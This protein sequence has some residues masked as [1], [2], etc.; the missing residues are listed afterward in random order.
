[1]PDLERYIQAKSMVLFVSALKTSQNRGH[2]REE[3]TRTFIIAYGVLNV[4]RSTR[5]FC[6]RHRPRYPKVGTRVVLYQRKRQV[7]H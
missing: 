2:L 6:I 3:N 4:S 5:R 1:M 7:S